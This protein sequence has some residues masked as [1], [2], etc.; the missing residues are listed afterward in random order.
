MDRLTDNSWCCGWF[1]GAFGACDDDTCEVHMAWERLRAYE[2]SRLTPEV[3]KSVVESVLA[4]DV[5]PV[6]RGKWV[7]YPRAH[8]FKCSNCKCTVPY[9]KAKL[10]NGKREYNCCPNCGARMDMDGGAEDG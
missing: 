10:I 9:K 6:V 4:A 1:C 3:C 8:Y 7:E 2:D 5:A